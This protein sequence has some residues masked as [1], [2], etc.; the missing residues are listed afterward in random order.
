M[1]KQSQKWTIII[2][3]V[4]LLLNKT[5]IISLILTN[6]RWKVQE[7][8]MCCLPVNKKNRSLLSMTIKKK[9]QLN[10]NWEKR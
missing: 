6:V 1:N 10:I 9:R 4:S 2:Y 7:S 5:V 3:H 8:H